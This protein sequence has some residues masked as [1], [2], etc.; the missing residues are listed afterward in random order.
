MSQWYDLKN[1]FFENGWDDWTL[2]HSID[3]GA[4]IKT[5]DSVKYGLMQGA[6]N[7][8]G[9]PLCGKNYMLIAREFDSPVGVS[10]TDQITLETSQ[11]YTL[12]VNDVIIVDISYDIITDIGNNY[13]SIHEIRFSNKANYIIF[14]STLVAPSKSVVS[15]AFVNDSLTTDTIKFAF[16][17]AVED[18]ATDFDIAWVSVD[19]IRIFKAFNHV[20]QS[21]ANDT[22][23]VA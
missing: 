10:Y 7:P 17:F 11:E 12:D 4:G 1:P 16:N 13:F 15:V 22:S 23:G 21:E 19:N 5:V 3:S 2:T 9:F 18:S 20:S 8:L 6:K 14:G